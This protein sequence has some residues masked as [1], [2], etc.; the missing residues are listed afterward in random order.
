MY[1]MDCGITQ[2]RCGSFGI[3]WA[4]DVLVNENSPAELAVAEVLAVGLKHRIRCD[5]AQHIMDQARH[6][7]SEMF[8]GW[9]LPFSWRVSKKVIG[10][11][12]RSS[13]CP[14]RESAL[15]AL[16]VL[17]ALLDKGW[18]KTSAKHFE[19]FLA[20]VSPREPTR[21]DEKE[22]LKLLRERAGARVPRFRVRGERPSDVPVPPGG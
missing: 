16:D 5:S 6:L 18:T 9:P 1:T 10:R 3:E 17:K 7:E 15:E 14:V 20:C 19:K 13:W 21:A 2:L 22:L 11:M 4:Y 8:G 12:V